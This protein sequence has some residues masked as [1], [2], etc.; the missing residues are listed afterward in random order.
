VTQ[1]DRFRGAASD[2]KTIR[3]FEERLSRAT[4]RRRPQYLRIKAIE[5]L[6][7]SDD[8]EAW[9]LAARLLGRVIDDYPDALDVPMA[10]VGL[11]RYHRR[12][13]EWDEA[14]R[15]FE[16]AIDLTSPSRSG[17]TGIEEADMAEVLVERNAPGD[18]T[19]ALELLAAE[20]L[21][22]QRHFNST[23]FR[24]AV[25]RA[26]AQSRLGMD[27]SAAAREALR[28]ASITEP[29]LPRHPTVGLLESDQQTL[30]E[31]KRYASG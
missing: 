25:C 6:D 4:P 16:L 18:N 14:L 26:R 9:D 20:H 21:L 15:H 23:L 30:E 5:I 13:S 22:S 19:R 28:L 27:P 17:S 12:L 8:P 31:L 11:A 29:Q 10:H 7:Q 3:A 1:R 24:I 2:A